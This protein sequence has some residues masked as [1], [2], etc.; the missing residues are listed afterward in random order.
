MRFAIGVAY[1]K[2]APKKKLGPLDEPRWH[3]PSVFLN[4]VASAGLSNHAQIVSALAVPGRAF[5][6]LPRAR[7]FF[8]HRSHRTAKELTSIAGKYHL[9]GGVRAG[10]L[11]CAAYPNRPYSIAYAWVTQV[12]A[13]MGLLAQ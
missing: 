2:K 7:N 6:D 8:A 11:P 5:D 3:V 1:P 12:K 9:G 10:E 13:T 4:L